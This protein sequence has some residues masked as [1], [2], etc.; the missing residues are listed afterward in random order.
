MDPNGERSLGSNE[1]AI[2]GSRTASGYPML[3]INP[4]VSFFGLSTYW[5]VHLE[6]AEGLSFSGLT[7]FGFETWSSQATS[8]TPRSTPPSL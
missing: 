8:S 1:W 7:R 4:H 5:E 6:S 3:L 2:S